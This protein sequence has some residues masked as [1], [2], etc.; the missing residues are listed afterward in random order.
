MYDFSIF[1]LYF[2]KSSVS[3]YQTSLYFQKRATGEINTLAH[4]TRGF[5]QSHPAYKHDSDVNDNIVYDLLK[6]VC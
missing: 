1:E 2:G 4:W 3:F 5:V 6:K